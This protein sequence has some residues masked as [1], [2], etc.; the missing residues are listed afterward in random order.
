MREEMREKRKILQKMSK[1][2]FIFL[3]LLFQVIINSWEPAWLI[4][5][6]CDMRRVF[7]KGDC[8]FLNQDPWLVEPW[9]TGTP[10]LLPLA[11]HTLSSLLASG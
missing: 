9:S 2:Q 8:E 7:G 10:S 1:A 6:I 3:I 5:G 11:P 4:G